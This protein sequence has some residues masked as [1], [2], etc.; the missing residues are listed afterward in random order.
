MRTNLT[1]YYWVAFLFLLAFTACKDKQ[2]KADNTKV[3]SAT[4]FDLNAA[5]AAIEQNN[6]SF[7]A[8]FAKGD[9]AAVAAHYASNAKL[10]PEGMPPVTGADNIKGLWGSLIRTGLNLKLDTRDVWGNSDVLTEEGTYMMSD[11]T[12]KE[13]ETGKY[14]VVWKQEGGQWKMFRDI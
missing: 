10:L 4:S 6:Q 8:D 1:N 3:A 11:K 5:K 7:L 13:I 9:S 12:G 2:A 14:I